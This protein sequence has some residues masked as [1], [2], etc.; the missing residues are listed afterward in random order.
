MAKEIDSRRL[1]R[2]L[3]D[4]AELVDVRET[5]EFRLETTKLGGRNWP[6]SSLGLRQK[7]ISQCRPTIFY[8]RSGMRSMQAA[9]IASDWTK[10]DVFFLHG[11]YLSYQTSSLYPN[12]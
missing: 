7:E 3:A 10:Q 2:L 6:L 11:G 1:E 9:E 4:G 8:C 5:E 12:N